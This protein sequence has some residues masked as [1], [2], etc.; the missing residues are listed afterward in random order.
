MK[1]PKIH[2]G[3][4]TTATQNS[5]KIRLLICH[6]AEEQKKNKREQKRKSM[7]VPGAH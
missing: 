4:E 7:V 3:K 1:E 6:L 2:W 5:N